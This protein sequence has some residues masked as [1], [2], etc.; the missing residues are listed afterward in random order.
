MQVESEE[1][2]NQEN[3]VDWVSQ[4]FYFFGIVDQKIGVGRSSLAHG[5]RQSS[6]FRE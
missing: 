5:K 3:C 1:E 6:Y 4:R 2:K